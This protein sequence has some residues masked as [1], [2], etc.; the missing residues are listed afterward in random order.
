MQVFS[1]CAMDLRC[2]QRLFRG[3]L[4]RHTPPLRCA[5]RLPLQRPLRGSFVAADHSR[6]YLARLE[7]CRHA[8]LATILR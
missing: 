5:L 4:R 2:P 7:I 3:R 1:S 8:W 6:N